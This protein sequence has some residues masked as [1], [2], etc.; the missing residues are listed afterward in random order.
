MTNRFYLDQF[1]RSRTAEA[2]GIDNRPPAE[3]EP[4]IRFTAA[5]L[6]RIWAAI[7]E[8]P[9]LIHSG[10]RSPAL[11]VAVGGSPKSQ[12]M[13]GE[14]VDFSAPAFGDPKTV[15]KFLSTQV[16]PLGIDQLILER[17][18]IH[19]SFTFTPR[20]HVLTYKDGKF[21]EGIV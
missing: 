17:S 13:K 8:V 6:E 1:V 3:L 4:A 21:F 5:G 9:V 10:Y 14:A 18:W 15:A 2:R 12:H 16:K 11:N 19:A 7:G 20:Y